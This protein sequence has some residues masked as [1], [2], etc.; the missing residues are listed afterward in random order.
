MV[1]CR[2]LSSECPLRSGDFRSSVL[3]PVPNV[4]PAFLSAFRGLCGRAWVSWYVLLPLPIWGSRPFPSHCRGGTTGSALWLS[5]GLSYWYWGVPDCGGSQSC[6]LPRSS[7]HD[8]RAEFL[9]SPVAS[10]F[11]YPL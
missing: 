3:V 1:T 7:G 2:F 6:P 10:D 4:P 9:P 11:W 5:S 8:T